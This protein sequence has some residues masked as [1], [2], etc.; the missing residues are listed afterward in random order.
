MMSI[1]R[2]ILSCALFLFGCI[3]QSNAQVKIITTIAGTGTAGAAGDGGAATAAQVSA[4]YGMAYYAPSNSLYIADQ[5]NSKVRRINLTTGIITTIAGTGTAGYTGEGTATAVRLNQPSGVAVDAAGNVLIADASNNR[6]RRVTPAGVISTIVGNGFGGFFGD[7]GLATNASINGPRSLAV[8][9]SGNIVFSDA[10]NQ[11]VRYVA[12]PSTT[13]RSIAGNGTAGYL[14][15]GVVATTT[16]INGPRGVAFDAAGDIYIADMTNSRIRK[17]TMSTLTISTV[18]GTGSAGPLGDGGA[19]TSAQ[20]NLPTGVTFD[21]AGN[22]II[23]DVSNNKIRMVNGAGTISTIVGTGTAGWAGDGA[24][25]TAAQISGPRAIQIMPN[26]SYYISDAGNNRIRL[27]KNNSTPYFVSGTRQNLIVCENDPATNI[28]AMLS[29]ID[30]DQL[31]TLTWSGIVFAPLH[32]TLVAAYTSPSNGGTVVPTGLSYTPTPGYNG[33]DS[34]VVRISDGYSFSTDT[35]V[36]TINPLPTV[37]AIAGPTSVC[38]AAT[39]TLVDPTS[40]GVWSSSSANATVTSGGVV[41]GVSAGTATISYTVTNSCGVISAT[42]NITINPLPDAG[43]ITGA[44]AVCVGSNITLTDV[45]PGGAWSASNTNASVLGGVVTGLSVG[46]VTIS[47]TVTN[48]CGTAIAS[49]NVNVLTTP[50]AGTITGPSSV[51]EGSSITLTDLAPGGVWTT[52][53]SSATVVGGL[54]T[55][56]SAGLDTIGYVVTNICGIATATHTV[57]VN[58]LP[59]SGTITGPTNVC[60]STTITLTDAAPGG[61]WSSS[62]PAVASITSG[63]VVTGL[64]VGTTTISYTV[65]NGCGTAISTTIVTS[66]ASPTAGTISGPTSVCVGANITLTDPVT[67][68]AWSAS[69]SN[70][71][72]VG[73]VVTGVAGGPVTISYT[74]TYS[75]GTAIATYP[76]TINPLAD[77]GTISGSSFVCQGGT[78]T[79]TDGVPGGTWSAT[80]SNATVSSA[81]LVTGLVVGVDTILYS[82]SNVCGAAS[83]THIISINPILNPSVSIL[84]SPGIANCPGVT[85]TYDATPVHGGTSPSYVWLVNGSVRAAGASFSYV[86]LNGDIIICR[87]TTSEA[88]VSAATVSDTVRAIVVPSLTPSATIS[89]GVWGDTVCSGDL[90]PFTVSPVNGGSTPSFTWSVNGIP[91]STGSTFNYSPANGDIIT[92]ALT[93]SYVCPTPATVNSNAIRMTVDVAQNPALTITSNPGSAV[94]VGSYATLTAHKLYGGPAPML[95]W[96][97]NG[98]NVAT[99]PTFAFIPTTGD[100]VFCTMTSSSSCRTYDLAVSNIITLTTVVPT[101]PTVSISAVSGS[102]IGIGQNNILIATVTPVTPTTTYQWQINGSNVPGATSNSYIFNQTSAGVSAVN[103]VVGSGDACNIAVVS[104]MLNIAVTT[105]V[106]NINESNSDVQLLPSPNNGV[107][108]VKG[109]FDNSNVDARIEL[110]NVVGQVVYSTTARLNNG[111]ID[112]EVNTGGALAN[113]VYMLHVTAENEHKTIRFVISK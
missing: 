32:G 112:Q 70:A 61:V 31:Q 68:G 84:A 88:C 100:N 113:G 35:F 11:R 30:S 99:G 8:D 72:V 25:A 104:N 10:N 82:V 21:A 64:T 38:E 97:K 15:D 17:V 28:S 103:C 66:I 67:G 20:V 41:T 83:A 45:A 42:Y 56:V 55:G 102:V 2:Y 44:T 7:G 85:V 47:Y 77:A 1:N 46:T 69:N 16:R 51:C 39:I 33:A 40:G 111:V 9:A 76:I 106:S 87:M 6:I 13:I 12:S 19:A 75:C 24:P 89:T 5:G 98:V 109:K 58:P 91:T 3:A 52:S 94:C 50:V 74:V 79:L 14:A 60:L 108:T 43:S 110:L 90:V 92:C 86:P 57:L 36:V 65:I 48:G 29:V 59:V 4:P 54:V 22:L 49:Y 62:D 73:G 37:A 95:L 107:F 34:F 63:G 53:N 80:N 96:T 26:G 81:G 105:G 18:A 23:S 93:S 78:T 27:V 101:T 71:T